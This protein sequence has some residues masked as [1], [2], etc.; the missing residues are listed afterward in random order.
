MARKHLLFWWS[1]NLCLCPVFAAPPTLPFIPVQDSCPCLGC[2]HP[3]LLVPSAATCQLLQN[4]PLLSPVCAEPVHLLAD[5]LLLMGEGS[6]NHAG[7][8][9]INP[10]VWS[11]ARCPSV[12]GLP[13]REPV[14][15]W[16]VRQ[17]QVLPPVLDPGIH[18]WIRELAFIP[19]SFLFSLSL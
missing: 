1:H 5:I 11:P 18:P 4:R 12:T 6:R 9:L 8:S 17:T 7:E 13:C 14:G 19:L 10:C 15:S 2:G 3:R 16:G